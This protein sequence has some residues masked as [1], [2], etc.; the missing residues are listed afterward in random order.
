[1]LAFDRLF[2]A[3]LANLYRLL[4]LP[5]P[6]QLN[7]PVSLGALNVHTDGAMRRAA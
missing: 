6:P 5:A 7:E 2:R 1:V 4:K 3:Y